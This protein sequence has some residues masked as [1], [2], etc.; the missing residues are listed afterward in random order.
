MAKLPYLTS[1]TL[2]ESVKRKI[3]FPLS[4][5]TFT[6][7]DVL[8]FADE[9]MFIAQ[10]PSILQF[11]SE[12][13]VTYKIVPLVTNVSR[14]P[15]PNRAIGMKLRD[16]FWM[17]MN[18][19][20]FEMTQVEEHDRAFY[21]RNLGTNQAL[22][23]F[24][25]EGNEIVL[26]PSVTNNPTG[27]MVFVFYLRPNQLVKDD[28]AATIQSFQQT[29]TINNSL[30]AALDTVTISPDAVPNTPI[31]L[32]PFT[33]VAS[34]GGTITSIVANGSA[35]ALITS[36]NHQLTEGQTVV[37]AGSDSNPSV[38]GTF[39][40]SV[41]SPNTFTINAQIVTPGTTGTFTSPNQFLIA[42]TSALTAANLAASISSLDI[43][44]TATS[45]GAVI[46][47]DFDNIYTQITTSNTPAF[48][49]P[50]TTIAINFTSLPNSYTDSETNVTEGLFTNGAVIDLLQRLP[51]HKT[52][53][54]DL[55]IQ[56]NAIS[57]TT[58]LFD[59]E[60]LFVPTGSVSDSGTQS[61]GQPSTSIQYML[62]P[63]IP[64]DYICLANE[65]IIPQ[66]PPDLHNGLAERTS[67]RILAALGDQAGLAA[68][69]QKIAEIETRQGNLMSNR[70]DGNPMKVTQRKSL[71]AWGKFRNYRRV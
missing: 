63:V 2:I 27:S 59:Q 6:A 53:V 19:N 43:I 37:I 51:G 44:N 70:S 10:V 8:A 23:K 69:N 62:A 60:Q 35:E 12:Y 33:A 4:Q 38:N 11:H 1:N 56:P 29:I 31:T 26:T 13:F 71:L 45:S 24:F 14:Y 47:L 57:G 32:V 5:N 3:S 52:Y 17:D 42:G 40:A 28:R 50:S 9:E 66:I 61:D 15:V 67:A 46:T 39:L 25:M 41:T 68:A 48:V 16:V 22:H 58:I 7:N 55:E 34:L 30:I 36:A 21:Q 18:G 65:A 49:I 54:Y 64:G 20:M